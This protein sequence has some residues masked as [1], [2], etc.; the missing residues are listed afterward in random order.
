MKILYALILSIL[1]VC[2]ASA[3]SKINA[4][5]RIM[6]SDYNLEVQRI[7][8]LKHVNSTDAVQMPQEPEISAIVVLK[9]GYTASVLDTI[10]S[11]EVL[12][13]MSGILVV[14]CPLL[15]AESIAK[16]P[17][18]MSVEFGRK[19]QPSL[20]YARPSG[21]VDAIHSGFSFD[22]S[23]VSYDGS[24]VIVG[25]MDTGLEA[26]HIN[27]K[28]DDG[29]SRIQRLWHMKSSD[30][31]YD[32]YTPANIKNFTT[33]NRNQGHATH[34]AGILGGSYKGNGTYRYAA[35]ATATGCSE[36]QNQP[37]PYYG[38]ATG[39]DLAFSVGE[40]YTANIVQGVTNIIDYAESVGKPAVVNLSLGHV[41]GPHDGTDA[42]CQALARLGERGIICMSAGNDG[43]K[44]ITVTK[45]LSS[46]TGN[47]SVLR[48]LPFSE[49]TS[50]NIVYGSANGIVD[51]WSSAGD[52]VTLTL[53]AL[54]GNTVGKAVTLLE[55]STSGTFRSSSSSNFSKYF[56]G[57][58]TIE[59]GKDA[60][61]NRYEVY[62]TLSGVS[63]LTTSSSDV[64][65]LELKAAQNTTLYAYA[66]SL[67]FD[68]RINTGASTITA[69]SKGN[70]DNS[71]NDGACAD[72]VIS[73]GAYTSRTTWGTFG[74][75][76]CYSYNSHS[77][78]NQLAPF[79][80]YGNKFINATQ[81]QTLP[82]VS[83]PGSTLVSSYSSYYVGS[84]T[85]SMT[86]KATVDGTTYYWGQMQGTSMSCPF[87]TGTIGLWLQADPTLDFARVMDV[88]NKTS[89]YDALTNGG[90]KAKWGAG[91][92]NG[93]EGMKEVLTQKAA[94]IG[95]VWA[96][97]NERLII[98]P[99]ADGYEVFVADAM[100][101]TVTVYDLQGRPVATATSAD[102]TA[103][104][105]TAS[106]GRGVYIIEARTPSL[107]LSRKVAL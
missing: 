20:N 35:S 99:V 12:S 19:M 39:A 76:S 3:Q 70:A 45:K 61:N 72:N 41:P 97:D 38:V 77:D 21:N 85:S 49:D 25:M 36:R 92:I 24:G 75:T 6:I 34:V 86:G 87:V 44:A 14:R 52:Q 40:L 104:V 29:S 107:R 98:S 42:Y 37:I 102:G 16:L 79:S 105:P 33:D 103:T 59:M 60:N 30:G 2:S 22:G 93:L 63:R 62:I 81:S 15:V 43:S 58:V 71:I 69:V 18:V 11:V 82:L 7:R 74:S 89:T 17:Q 9:E 55:C 88:I 26:N 90:T 51:I 106:L 10:A 91:M 50:G 56:N 66:N 53:K 65:L 95:E 13:D 28:N 1:A 94:G 96:D 64:L 23:T 54:S 80:S 78:V 67:V 47:N 83:G 68:N 100:D 46:A 8:E 84:S 73:V 57:S 5:G 4:E 31:S 48:L 27:F 32:V 101:L